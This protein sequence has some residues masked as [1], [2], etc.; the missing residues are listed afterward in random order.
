M[1]V[2]FADFENKSQFDIYYTPKQ[3]ISVGELFYSTG[4]PFTD[5]NIRT[6]IA[7]N[8]NIT[9]QVDHIPAGMTVLYP[10]NP[11]RKMFWNY[12]LG[13]GI[14]GVVRLE[15][16]RVFT[17]QVKVMNK[18]VPTRKEIVLKDQKSIVSKRFKK[19]DLFMGGAF[20]YSV[21]NATETV[22]GSVFEISSRI[23]WA[24][25]AYYVLHSKDRWMIKSIASF[26]KYSF[27]PAQYRDSLNFGLQT[28]SL[29]LSAVYHISD[30]F[31][32]YGSF[33]Y[34]THFSLEA[35]TTSAFTFTTYSSLSPALGIS[36]AFNQKAHFYQLSGELQRV[37]GATLSYGEIDPSYITR[38]Y[39]DYRP[40]IV[41]EWRPNFR[42]GLNMTS[43]TSTQFEQSISEL[44]L[45]VYF[46]TS[47]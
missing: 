4:I 10:F 25:E 18:I 39:L 31:K 5:F 32:A 37:G 16:R 43:K 23:N 14:D 40:N 45:G 21:V 15:L 2:A 28:Y 38:F 1:P 36:Y 8:K 41:T 17:T 44:H 7:V 9:N 42:I 20:K 27:F 35:V 34:G 11:G 46:L 24:L 33:T 47:I 29:G 30:V 12:D 26:T 22:S 6:F 3:N 13:R 19:S